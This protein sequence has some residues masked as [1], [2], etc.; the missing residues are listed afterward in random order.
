MKIRRGRRREQLLGDLKE[1]RG[2]CTQKKEA[3]YSTPWST[4]LG[5]GCG[6]VVR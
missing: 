2:Y 4:G 1:N 5:R 6:P 3:V